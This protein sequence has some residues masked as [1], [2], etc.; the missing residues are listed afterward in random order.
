MSQIDEKCMY[1]KKENCKL[2]E[3]LE[4]I[5]KNRKI[6]QE[7]YEE[8]KESFQKKLSEKDRIIE[9]LNREVKNQT[10]KCHQLTD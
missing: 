3:T 2:K 5:L 6:M 9:Q 7:E 8:T 10:G 4:V 1:E